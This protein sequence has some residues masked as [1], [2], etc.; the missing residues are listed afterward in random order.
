ME[1]PPLI[2]NGKKWE[3]SILPGALVNSL[4]L[5]PYLVSFNNRLTQEA[6]NNPSHAS[7]TDGSLGRVDVS[8]CRQ[9]KFRDF[10]PPIIKKNSLWNEPIKVILQIFVCL[11]T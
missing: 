2:A 11:V 5:Q 1:G 4:A 6:F 8:L 3:H 7:V 10:I 9:K